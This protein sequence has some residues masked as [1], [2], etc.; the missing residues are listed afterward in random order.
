MRNYNCSEVK[1][2]A[3]GRQNDTVGFAVLVMARNRW[4]LYESCEVYV[5]DMWPYTMTTIELTA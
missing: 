5:E 4:L 3:F 1:G 2:K